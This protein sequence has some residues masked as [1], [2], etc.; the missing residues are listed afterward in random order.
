MDLI[1]GVRLTRKEFY[2][3]LWS[4][5]KTTLAKQFGVSDSAV[6]KAAKK[7]NIPRPGPGYWQK[8]RNGKKVKPVPL[9]LRSPGVSDVI[10]FSDRWQSREEKALDKILVEPV[11][12]ETFKEVRARVVVQIG[13]VTYPTINK[14]PHSIIKKLLSKDDERRKEYEKSSYSWYQPKFDTQIEKRRLRMFNALFIK[15]QTIGCCPYMGTGKYDEYEEASFSVGEQHVR[16]KLEVI[17]PKQRGRQSTVKKPLL[18]CTLLKGWQDKDKEPI[19]EDTD[20]SRIED[21][22]TSIVIE[23]VMLGEQQYRNLL[24][25][26]YEWDVQSRDERIEEERQRIIEEER[27]VRE[28]LE[29]EEKTRIDLL[30]RQAE[31]IRKAEIIREYVNI[32]LTKAGEIDKPIQEIEAWADWAQKQADS[33]DPIKNFAGII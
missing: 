19:W 24:Q 23:I 28:Q 6:G 5:P 13:K 2:E 21:Y 25:R 4:E 3:L 12:E 30:L 9:P 29:R 16:I 22:L 17:E 31:S 20:S 18:K 8:V 27:Q 14:S 10:H 1:M 7:A 32:V 33:I 11:Y 15:L 26:L